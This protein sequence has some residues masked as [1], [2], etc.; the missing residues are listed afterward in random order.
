M[1]A[2]LEW[3]QEGAARFSAYWS[4]RRTRSPFS[5]FEARAISL[6][7]AVRAAPNEHRIVPL[8]RQF[9]NF[10]FEKDQPRDG[11]SGQMDSL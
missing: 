11:A 1:S 7:F 9:H 6:E 5:A 4:A 8:A 3:G 2:L 10:L